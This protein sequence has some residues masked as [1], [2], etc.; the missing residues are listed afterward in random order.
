MGNHI[1]CEIGL[2]SVD[3]SDQLLHRGHDLVREKIWLDNFLNEW[4]DD[5]LSEYQTHH[6]DKPF[7]RSP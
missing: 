4:F 3:V 2:G 6:Q 5:V 7:E 1:R